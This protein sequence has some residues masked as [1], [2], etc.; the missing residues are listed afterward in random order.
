MITRSP[1]TDPEFIR[2][3]I[4]I[5]LDAELDAEARRMDMIEAAYRFAQAHQEEE[6]DPLSAAQGIWC[7]ILFSFFIVLAIYLVVHHG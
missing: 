5:P 6:R 7:G 4:T 1:F 3:R 2:S